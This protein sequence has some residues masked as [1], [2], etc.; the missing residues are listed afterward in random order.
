MTQ[1]NILENSINR[2]NTLRGPAKILYAPYTLAMPLNAE[3]VINATSGAAASGWT[4]LGLTRGGINVVKNE[5]T[6]ERDDVDQILGVYAQD[7][8]ARSWRVSTQL[9]EVLDRTQRYIA[10]EMGTPTIV[11]TSG[12]TQVMTPLDDGD[13]IMTPRRLAV[14][15]PKGTNGRILLYVFRWAERV[16][17]EKTIR[18]AKDDPASPPLE[19]VMMPEQATTLDAGEFYGYEF[20]H[21]GG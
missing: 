9:A 15:W 13:N 4:S 20:E 7:I 17:G 11:S 1:R 5:E 12:A 10:F 2:L 14:V 6:T 18:F 19:W 3:Q 16:G 21:I 8:T